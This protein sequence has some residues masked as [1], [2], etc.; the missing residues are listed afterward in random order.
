MGSSGIVFYNTR[1]KKKEPFRP[2]EPR[3]VRLYSC[4]PTVYGPVHI[5][6]LRSW[7]F[8][9]LLKRFLISEGFSVTQV[10]N[11]TDV[12]HLVSDGD[13]GEDKM[14]LAARRSGESAEEIAARYTELWRQDRAALGCLEPEHNPRASEHIAEQIELGQKLEAGGYL[15]RI[16]DGIYFDVSLFPRY[17]ELAGLD[18]EG[19]RDVQR[20][21][22]V[23]GKR[24]PADFAIW[25][26]AE[27]GVKRLQEWD[28][29]WGRGFPGWHLECS[30]MA[31][32][33]LGEEIDIHTGGIDLAS[34]HHTNEVAQSE[35]GFGVHPWVRHWMHNEFLDFGGEKMSKSKGNV[36]TLSDLTGRGYDPMAFRYFFLQ[37]HYRQQQNFNAEAMDA[38]DT[39][40]RRLVAVAAELRGVEGPGSEAVQAPFKQRFRAALADDLNAPRAM[41]V[42][43]DVARSDTLSPADR[44][45]L[46]LAFDEV[47]GLDLAHAKPPAQEYES[48]PR[49][50]GLVAERQAA[51]AGKDF[52]TA[53]RI[54][55]ELDAEG[56]GIVDTPEGPRWRRK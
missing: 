15:Y 21:D 18:L 24:H 54:R 47:L 29:P 4:G 30:A 14:E 38:A 13:E 36:R 49:I 34:V 11:I 26:F 25:K 45:D 37:A 33:Y 10:I 8:S 55:D 1:R 7:L 42:V 9:D 22:A 12:G 56:I 19:Q 43:W 52:A 48:D 31:V 50:D 27:P 5:G 20:I 28:S 17:T 40:Y 23:K 44:R 39:G 2:I 35:C 41:A 6:N 46:L 16:E 53:D 3:R 51:R 32:K